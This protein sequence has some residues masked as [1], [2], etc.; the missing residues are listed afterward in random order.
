LCARTRYALFVKF[1]PR[2]PLALL[3][4][5]VLF[6]LL[7]FPWRAASAAGGVVSFSIPRVLPLF[8]IYHLPALALIGFLLRNE[9]RARDALRPGLQDLGFCGLALAALLGASLP[10]N[11]LAQAL[12]LRTPVLEPPSGAAG[13]AALCVASLGTGYLE[14]AWFRLYLPLKLRNAGAPLNAALVFSALLFAL[15]HRYEGPCGMLNAALAA[16]V[17]SLILWKKKRFHAIALAHALY[18]L[19]SFL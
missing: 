16:A 19:F 13:W 5:L 14:E 1:F 8:F 18:N 10:L 4:P 11:A 15:C 2:A 7:F 17:F 12:R 3:E 9:Q 6:L